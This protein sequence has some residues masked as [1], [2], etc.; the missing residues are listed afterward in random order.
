MVDSTEREMTERER[1]AQRNRRGCAGGMGCG[2]VGLL[3]FAGLFA[4][5]GV[6]CA[7][8]D[9]AKWGMGLIFAMGAPMVGMAL[10]YDLKDGTVV[11]IAKTSKDG[12]RLIFSNVVVEYESS[13]GTTRRFLSR[14]STTS[15]DFQTLEPG[16]HVRVLECSTDPDIVQ[17]LGHPSTSSKTCA[18]PF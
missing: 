5:L 4:Y 1:P 10:L 3:S 16:M 13:D 7:Q 12:S 11:S 18:P 2:A 8:T 9:E 6:Q 15:R 17:L 14:M